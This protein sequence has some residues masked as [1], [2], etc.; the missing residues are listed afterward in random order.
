MLRYII[1]RIAISPS[2][3]SGLSL[4]ACNPTIASSGWLMIGVAKTPPS[5]P[6]LVSVQ[7]PP[8]ISSRAE[9][10]RA[11]ALGLVG[12][13][14]RQLDHVLAVG[15]ANHRHDQAFRGV[16]RDSDVVVLL[17]QNLLLFF[18][19]R[20]VEDRVLLES[21]NQ[22]LDK[23][24]QKGETDAGPLLDHR[25]GAAVMGHE[26]R[27]VSFVDVSDVCCVV[28]GGAHRVGDHLA[29]MADRDPLHL[30]I[31]GRRHDT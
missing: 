29:Q 16:N 28:L 11:G 15:V 17:E 14:R 31:G 21:R 13:L 10:T 2:T 24:G 26:V 6:I 9:L 18:V 30:A 23:E 12:H 22:R 1:L 4:I 19:D 8:L 7:L 20:S 25:F 27:D 3:T 5:G